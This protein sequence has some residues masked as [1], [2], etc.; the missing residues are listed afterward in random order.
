MSFNFFYQYLLQFSYY[1]LLYNFFFHIN[2]YLTFPFIIINNLFFL[3]T[4]DQSN[5]FLT[6]NNNTDRHS[7]NTFLVSGIFSTFILN[8]TLKRKT[9]SANP[10]TGK[11]QI[12]LLKSVLLFSMVKLLLI[13]I[14]N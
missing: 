8:V 13:D 3:L 7:G 1:L 12:I 2:K 4:F 5:S 11:S 6:K 14:N 9:R 10:N